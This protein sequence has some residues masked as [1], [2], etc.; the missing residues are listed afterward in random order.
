M[1]EITAAF[2][3]STKELTWDLTPDEMYYDGYDWGWR[4]ISS[5]ETPLIDNSEFVLA[6]S[7]SLKQ[8]FY[9]G[10]EQGTQDAA[11][12]EEEESV[13]ESEDT[14]QGE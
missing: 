13:R 7:M 6:S 12:A 11:D 2:L 3:N 1:S 5:A 9:A 4:S 8:C 10:Y 14:P